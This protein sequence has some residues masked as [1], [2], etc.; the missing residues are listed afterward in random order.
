MPGVRQC[1]N[2]QGEG[3]FIIRCQNC[4]KGAVVS[5]DATRFDGSPTT[6]WRCSH[7]GEEYGAGDRPPLADAYNDRSR[8]LWELVGA[9]SSDGHALK[10]G[11]D[12]IADAAEILTAI[13]GPEPGE[14]E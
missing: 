1:G 9:M 6:A 7:C 14:G 3:R 11:A 10:C 5:R 8:K 13:Y 4:P 2:H 12:L